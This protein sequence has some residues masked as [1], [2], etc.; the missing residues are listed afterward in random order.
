MKP[1]K[2]TRRK[3]EPEEV[4]CTPA[5]SFPASAD[6]PES[7]SR[8]TRGAVRRLSTGSGD[9][10]FHTPP[11]NPSPLLSSPPS[12]GVKRLL[13]VDLRTP[14]PKRTRG[15]AAAAEIDIRTPPEQ[16]E[17]GHKRKPSRA[18]PTR[19]RAESADQAD[20]LERSFGSPVFALSNGGLT[21]VPSLE[22]PK[23]RGS[24]SGRMSRGRE[25]SRAIQLPA[26]T[27]TTASPLAGSERA[28]RGRSLM[29]SPDTSPNP[30]LNLYPDP[31]PTLRKTR[32]S[33]VALV[34]GPSLEVLAETRTRRGE[35]GVPSSP[36]RSRSPVN[37]LP[38]SPAGFMTP[39]QSRGKKTNKSPPTG[40]GSDEDG[41][42]MCTPPQSAK[43]F[44][45]RLDQVVS[46]RESLGV[47]ESS[48]TSEVLDLAAG[49][50][51]GNVA[52]AGEPGAGTG[53]GAE[54][55]QSEEELEMQR[56]TIP[57]RWSP[58]DPICI[59]AARS[60]MHPSLAPTQIKCRDK[61]RAQILSFLTTSVRDRTPGSMYVSG[62]PGTGK[63]LAVSE[64]QGMLKKWAAEEG[65][66]IPHVVAINCMT[67]RDPKE[68]YQ[69]VLQEIEVLTEKESPAP[70]ARAPK[71][72]PTSKLAAASAR[73][74]SA[75]S[76]GP[77]RGA[78]SP[79][80]SGMV[81]VILDEM[82]R[83]V[84]RD[85]TVLYE[86]FKLATAPGSRCLLVGIANA[87]DLM[88]RFLPNLRLMNC[89][90]EQLSF[91]SYDKEQIKEIL[92]QRLSHLPFTVFDGIALELCARKFA[93][94]SG[95]LR[96]ALGVCRLAL[97][98]AIAEAQ[99][100]PRGPVI[101]PPSTPSPTK[102]PPLAPTRPQ[103]SPSPIGQRK[104]PQKLGPE[105]PETLGE[106][107]DGEKRSDDG[108]G[109]SGSEVRWLR[110]ESGG[111]VPV[112][113]WTVGFGHMAEAF[114]QTFPDT[115]VQAIKSLPQHHQMVLCAAVLLF[116]KNKKDALLGGLQAEYGRLCQRTLLRPLT[117]R[118]FTDSCD[119]LAAQA[120]LVIGPA[121]EQ[122][123]RRVTMR[124]TDDD[125]TFALQGIRF[126]RN[127]LTP[128]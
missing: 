10:V 75:L 28:S 98:I 117:S 83:L 89:F 102:R 82:D 30:P 111:E 94:S 67:L 60:A 88:E 48:P 112:E 34:D 41:A 52:E 27:V 106:V 99:Q 77:N 33:S 2:S 95:D 35:S 86:M 66:P 13:E 81:V 63:S 31:S 55:M 90:P 21:D 38:T 43:D 70:S 24:D 9:D 59:E 26:S 3:A 22:T 37:E 85:Q 46:A 103:N 74:Q 114:A 19:G 110:N 79:P 118:E 42:V 123:H 20:N 51:G 126:F 56:P 119:V 25:S 15:A 57:D 6:S 58:L 40:G 100:A 108:S 97:S 62:Q 80:E 71:W 12:R 113:K 18:K 36:V 107:F 1:R 64:A 4:F 65:L 50:V 49:R 8:V 17:R 72:E 125:V 127:L 115:A 121:K 45:T 11:Q 96:K 23:A 109:V 68:V 61:E 44:Q 7:K 39:V 53:M 122:K 128:A 124:A 5:Q 78:K 16:L 87:I 120:L 84:S 76:G 104:T 54:A 47:A 91:R 105:S 101:V 29:G 93:T 116:R 69:R 73:L 92:I 32:R 14:S